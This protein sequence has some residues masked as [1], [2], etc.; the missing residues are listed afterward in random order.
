MYLVKKTVYTQV[1]KFSMQCKSYHAKF[2]PQECFENSRQSD[3]GE[4]KKVKDTVEVEWR[5][6]TSDSASILAIKII[7]SKV[8]SFEQHVSVFIFMNVW[9]VLCDINIYFS[10]LQSTRLDKISN[11]SN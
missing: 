11:N 4:S 8:C 2:A 9:L 10:C 7:P 1:K 5:N 3:S 6:E